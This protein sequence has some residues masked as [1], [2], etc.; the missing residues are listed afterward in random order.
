MR[1]APLGAMTAA[2]CSVRYKSVFSEPGKAPCIFFGA[3]APADPAKSRAAAAARFVCTDCGTMLDAYIDRVKNI[4]AV[5][6]G[7]EFR[8][9]PCKELTLSSWSIL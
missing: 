2:N 9:P 3:A 6:I 5:G 1:M 8:E 4:L 7:C